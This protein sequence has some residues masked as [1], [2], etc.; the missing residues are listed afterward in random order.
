MFSNV[1]R[2][3][4]ISKFL[5][6]SV[7]KRVFGSQ[8]LRWEGPNSQREDPSS[9]SPS[10]TRK[11]GAQPE[12]AEL[13]AQQEEEPEPWAGDQE[14]YDDDDDDDGQD[15]WAFEEDETLREQKNNA[16][17]MGRKSNESCKANLH[18]SSISQENLSQWNLDAEDLFD[19]NESFSSEKDGVAGGKKPGMCV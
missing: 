2:E 7:L 3:K 4:I 15:T 13:F 8:Q 11:A 16:N 5:K 6:G 9:T 14:D 17:K 18:S 19:E 10:T 12:P 1:Q